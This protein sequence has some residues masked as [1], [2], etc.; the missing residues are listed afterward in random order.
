MGSRA[1]LL[2]VAQLDPVGK[3]V[4][5]GLDPLDRDEL[6]EI[7]LDHLPA[8]FD[9]DGQVRGELD[10]RPGLDG[11]RVGERQARLA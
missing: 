11:A 10:A 3:S 6:V 8:Q 4:G 5:G 7:R 9:A 2:G 1:N